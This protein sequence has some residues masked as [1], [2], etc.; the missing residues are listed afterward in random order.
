M[1]VQ[2]LVISTSHA[3]DEDVVVVDGSF[4]GEVVEGALVVVVIGGVVEETVLCFVVWIVV[5]VCGPEEVV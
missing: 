5:V 3:D 1:F 4:V 2:E